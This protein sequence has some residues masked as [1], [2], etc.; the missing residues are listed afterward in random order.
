MSAATPQPWGATEVAFGEACEE[1]G[2]VVD[3]GTQIVIHGPG[4]GRQWI[5][6]IAPPSGQTAPTPT[7]RAN[8]DTILAAVLEREVL[9][10]ALDQVT[11]S[12]MSLLDSVLLRDSL[13]AHLAV[14][15][16]LLSAAELVKRARGG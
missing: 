12:T 6:A 14:R 16:L 1:C 13:E 10:N 11:K 7:N 3:L 4:P 5:A 15:P 8:A 2:A 9:I